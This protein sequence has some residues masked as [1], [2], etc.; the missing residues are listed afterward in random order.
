MSG[1]VGFAYLFK[2]FPVFAQTFVVR[3]VEGL[4]RHGCRP[5]L[6]A[7]QPAPASDQEGFEAMRRRT[8]ILPGGPALAA[9]ILRSGLTGKLPAAAFFSGAWTG[10]RNRRRREAFWLGPKLCA[11]G[12]AHVHTHFTGPA[13]RTAW[14]LQQDFGL[15]YSITAHANDFLSE[16]DEWPG[17]ERV[18]TDASFVVAVSDYSRHLL[19]G[20]FPR[21]RLVRVYNGMCLDTALPPAPVAP[22]LIVA[23]GRLVEKKGYPVL[24]D[25][26]AQLK[27]RGVAFR[28]QIIG[29]G[30]LEQELR[31]QITSRGVG[32]QVELAGP[33]TQ[34]DIRRSLAAASVFVL[35][36][37]EEKSGGMDILPTV[38]TEAMAAS[39]PVV[40]TRLAGVP[41]M[42]VH[43]KTGLLVP[44]GDPTAVAEAVQRLLADPGEARALGAAGRS[45]AE[46]IF[47]EDVTIPQLLAL[48]GQKRPQALA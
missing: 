45:H 20:R 25:A 44:P 33:R 46:A 39:L 23:V 47:S 26:C 6:Y 29:E 40:S 28:C 17:L 1:P 16:A 27:Q 2:K 48:L 15:S 41:E 22:A 5:D 24:I 35:P 4:E 31:R 43:G 38:I 36:C 14:W 10:A 8:R 12:V 42:V 7:L 34:P 32:D 3:E 13:A 9:D 37:V 18:L 30:P 21:A 19:A 11:A